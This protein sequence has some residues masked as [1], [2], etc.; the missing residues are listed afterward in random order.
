M[1]VIEGADAAPYRDGNVNLIRGSGDDAGEIIA[2]V[3]AGHNIHEDDFVSPL[4]VVTQCKRMRVTH[5]T[6]TLQ[7]NT[8]DQ[9]VAFDIQP[10]NN[11]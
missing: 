7:A 1:Y 5:D 11:A 8:F 3:K 2:L 6:Q 9:V 4:R 10:G